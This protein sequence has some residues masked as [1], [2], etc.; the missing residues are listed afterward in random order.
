M[1]PTTPT[2]PVYRTGD[3]DPTHDTAPGVD[4]CAHRMGGGLFGG[5]RCTWPTGHEHSQHVAG[6]GKT[7][8]HVTDT[9]RGRDDTGIVRAL[10]TGSIQVGNVRLLN[11]G[12]ILHANTGAGNTIVL[13]RDAA[14]R[15][16][17]LLTT[18]ADPA[19]DTR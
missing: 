19:P 13:D 18:W 3:P 1:E 12:T 14:L 9:N 6:T 11:L 17:V 2:F 8:A 5:Y 15:L 7:V 4:R 10:S 16:A